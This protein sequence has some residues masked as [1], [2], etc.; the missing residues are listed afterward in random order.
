[1]KSVEFKFNLNIEYSV[2]RDISFI[3]LSKRTIAIVGPEGCGKSSVIQL[4]LRLYE[5]SAGI[6]VSV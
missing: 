4:L 6:I 1:M 3:A 5:P 2:L